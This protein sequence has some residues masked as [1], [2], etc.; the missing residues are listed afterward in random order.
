MTASKKVPRCLLALARLV[1]PSFE[2]CSDA[3]VAETPVCSGIRSVSVQSFLVVSV[4]P[5]AIRCSDAPPSS[6]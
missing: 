4:G 5:Y 1:P 3:V 2:G 6:D